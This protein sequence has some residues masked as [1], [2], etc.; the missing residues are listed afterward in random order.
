MSIKLTLQPVAFVDSTKPW[1]GSIIYVGG[2]APAKPLTQTQK[3]ALLAE[4]T[5][6]PF[7]HRNVPKATA[8]SKS[9]TYRRNDVKVITPPRLTPLDLVI[10]EIGAISKSLSRK[11]GEDFSVEDFEGA[12]LDS[13]GETGNERAALELFEKLCHHNL[14]HN[15]NGFKITRESLS[16]IRNQAASIDLLSKIAELPDEKRDITLA[17]KFISGLV[18]KE[19]NTLQKR[20]EVVGFL[21]LG[22][23]EF[24]KTKISEKAEEFIQDLC[25]LNELGAEGT[26]RF[27]NIALKQLEKRPLGVLGHFFHA[28]CAIGLHNA[29]FRDFKLCIPIYK[30]EQKIEEAVS[31]IDITCT[32]ENKTY[33]FEVKCYGTSLAKHDIYRMMDIFFACE[34]R[35]GSDE[36]RVPALLI[37]GLKS[38]IENGRR[39]VSKESVNL[40]YYFLKELDRV[41]KENNVDLSQ[42]RIFSNDKGQITDITTTVL[43]DFGLSLLD[44]SGELGYRRS[45]ERV[46]S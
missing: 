20:A 42:L 25:V 32:K 1:A 15:L 22:R 10:K 30:G 3:P 11:L 36:I 31:D 41:G 23:F 34:K 44:H 40:V 16:T 9:K 21:Q 43:E 18:N 7:R 8:K 35:R 45:R 6:S 27:F 5:I 13:I 46:A 14:L 2:R 39:E 17:D 38:D 12:L 29:G 37:G 26:D 33:V 4:R 28:K 24:I 19:E